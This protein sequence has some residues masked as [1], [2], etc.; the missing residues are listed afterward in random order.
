VLLATI[1]NHMITAW[2]EGAS[3]SPTFSFKEY[4]DELCKLA[5]RLRNMAS[6]LYNETDIFKVKNN[7]SEKNFNQYLNVS[8]NMSHLVTQDIIYQPTIE[9]A[10]IT[11]DRWIHICKIAFHQHD[12]FTASS[13]ISG[14]SSLYVSKCGIE[15]KLSPTATTLFAYYL[16]LHDKA[17]HIYIR[18]KS[19]TR[20]K[21]DVV[22][23]L[24]TLTHARER[25]GA[26]QSSDKPS[27]VQE[28]ELAFKKRAISKDFIFLQKKVSFKLDSE[29]S[30]F[31][32]K[33]KQTPDDGIMFDFEA[34]SNILNA[35]MVRY[36]RS[37]RGTYKPLSILN[38][39][40]KQDVRI[41]LIALTDELL[42]LQ[43]KYAEPYK[44]LLDEARSILRSA[45]YTDTEMGDKLHDKFYLDPN[46]Q[47]DKPLKKI[48]KSIL[49]KL[50]FLIKEEKLHGKFIKDEDL[51]NEGDTL[52][53]SFEMLVKNISRKSLGAEHKKSLSRDNEELTNSTSDQAQPISGILVMATNAC[54]EEDEVKTVSSASEQILKPTA[55]PI[56]SPRS[57]PDSSS[58]INKLRQQFGDSKKQGRRASISGSARPPS[59]K[60]FRQEPV[61]IESAPS[62]VRNE[63]PSSKERS[64]SSSGVVWIQRAKK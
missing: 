19:L 30:D 31:L 33:L 10:V 13:I 27:V 25:V 41:K 36:G 23:V 7:V 17:G 14:L 61:G 46:I 38:F 57:E 43:D 32:D 8:K 12:F 44:N 2:L 64:A 49:N 51:K 52:D 62:S 63:E 20:N 50:E 18:L 53:K 26:V 58:R 40:D 45:M 47:V 11:M 5:A 28:L 56:A 4:D 9:Q 1:E 3:K 24:Y 60:L 48:Y 22:P 42:N 15:K 16:N 35:N 34:R 39:S 59:P 21:L 29:D 54:S 37:P 6:A 55:A